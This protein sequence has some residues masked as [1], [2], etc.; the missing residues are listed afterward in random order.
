[1]NNRGFIKLIILITIFVAILSILRVDLRTIIS[2]DMIQKNFS[3]VW[4]AAKSVWGYFYNEVWLKNST[5][6][7]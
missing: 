1:M 5:P 7:K 6:I 2:S 3:C 4:E